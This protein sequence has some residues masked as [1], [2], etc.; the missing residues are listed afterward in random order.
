MQAQTAVMRDW[1]E[2]TNVEKLSDKECSKIANRI[3][4]AMDKSLTTQQRLW[5]QWFDKMQEGG[6]GAVTESAKRNLPGTKD[7]AA[8]EPRAEQ[9]KNQ[10]RKADDRDELAEW[11]NLRMQPRNG[12]RLAH[13]ALR[14]GMS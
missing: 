13:Q 3:V 7:K 14:R 1:A 9:T 11:Q 12:G 6:K 4:K 5:S 2:M 8:S 10:T